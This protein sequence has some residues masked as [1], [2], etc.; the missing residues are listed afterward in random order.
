MITLV[1]EVINVPIVVVPNTLKALVYAHLD[2]SG[3]PET[4]PQNYHEIADLGTELIPLGAD[5]KMPLPNCGRST[6]R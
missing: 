1:H 4:P 5:D 3:L 6:T 2:L